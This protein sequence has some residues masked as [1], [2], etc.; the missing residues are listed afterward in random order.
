M[1]EKVGFPVRNAIHQTQASFTLLLMRNLVEMS[2]RQQHKYFSD[3]LIQ[4]VWQGFS[5]GE[6]PVASLCPVEAVPAGSTTDLL[7]SK[8][9]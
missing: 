9:K 7:L 1:I 5:G 3:I 4:E 6:L 8:A 2:L